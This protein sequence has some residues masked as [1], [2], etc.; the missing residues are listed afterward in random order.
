MMERM[1]AVLVYIIAT[2]LTVGLCVFFAPKGE[3]AELRIDS[4]EG[5][6]VQNPGRKKRIISC[7]LCMLPLLAVM[8]CRWNLGVDMWYTYAPGYLALKSEAVSLTEEEKK[9]IQTS[10]QLHAYWDHWKENADDAKRISLDFAQE[11]Y[12][13]DYHHAGIG[14]QLVERFL[15][16]LR[17]DVQWFYFATSL[18]VI[19]F[20][21]ASFWI[22]NT[23][24]MWAALLFVITANFFV[25]LS[26][27]AQYIAVAICVFA[28]FFAEK[29]KPV[30]FFLLV[31]IAVSIHYSAIVFIPV[32]FLP[33]LKIKPLWC[34]VIVAVCLVISRFAFPVIC[35]VVQW[36]A[37]KYTGYID[38]AVG[39]EAF[40]W[41]FFGINCAVFALGTYYYPKGKDLPYYRLWYY[42][43]VLGMICIAFSGIVPWIKRMNYYYAATHCLFIP[44]ALSLEENVV[45]RRV[46]HAVTVA[47]F[48]AE[49]Y[50]AIFLL[51]K[52]GTLPYV[53]FFQGDRGELMQSMFDLI[54]GSR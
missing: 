9:T 21:F 18:F 33:K 54:A 3:K 31:G 8:S 34:A 49:I 42:I 5:S 7:F 11:F 24:P 16:L 6:A 2:L 14:F 20:F 41:I 43:N 53:A 4:N 29:R 32:Y 40:E 51:N 46:F 26:V 48:C 28:C 38:G 45:R 13:K 12:L 47:L 1:A 19:G 30:W 37:P 23:R 17:A 15:A 10:M 22:Q 35:Q 36:V 44:L 25:A 39:K 52:H 50:V 27:V